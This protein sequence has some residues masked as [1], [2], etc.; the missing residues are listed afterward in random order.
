MSKEMQHLASLSEAAVT[1]SCDTLDITVHSL[2]EHTYAHH[3]HD[4]A[5]FLAQNQ[6]FSSVYTTVTSRWT[7]TEL[8]TLIANPNRMFLLHFDRLYKSLNVFFYIQ[9]E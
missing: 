4:D 2:R 7:M 1:E 3:S 8:S 9:T 6:Y 5:A